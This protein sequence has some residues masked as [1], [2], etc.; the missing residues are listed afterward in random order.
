MFLNKISKEKFLWNSIYFLT[1][2]AAYYANN[3]PG[4][5]KH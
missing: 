5:N 2:H 4:A 1:L 3:E